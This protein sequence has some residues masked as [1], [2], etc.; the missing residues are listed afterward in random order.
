MVLLRE[1]RCRLLLISADIYGLLS[2]YN[3][4]TLSVLT[5][6]LIPTDNDFLF[7]DQGLWACTSKCKILGHSDDCWC[8]TA[9][10]T[11]SNL[12]HSF[13]KMGSL[14]HNTLGR[15]NYQA[16]IPKTEGLQNV[17]EKVMY[18]EYDYITIVNSPQQV[19]VHEMNN[20]TIPVYSPTETHF[21]TH[22][23]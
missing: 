13:A 21:S 8:P 16:H 19:R 9:A 17:C 6:K 15:E 10:M 14:Q 22:E 7:V 4:S 12:A 23:V 3:T 2:M 1:K 5:K 20:I 18:R 11:N